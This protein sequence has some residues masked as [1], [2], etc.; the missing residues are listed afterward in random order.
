MEELMPND[1]GIRFNEGVNKK[2]AEKL[3]KLWQLA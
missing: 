1:I 3:D 2:T